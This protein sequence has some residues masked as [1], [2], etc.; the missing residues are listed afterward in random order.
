MVKRYSIIQCNGSGRGFRQMDTEMKKR[1][2]PFESMFIRV[3]WCGGYAVIVLFRHATAFATGFPVKRLSSYD[4]LR[5][6]TE[7]GESEQE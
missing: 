2:H 1:V 4:E 6:R 7:K 3:Q 5:R